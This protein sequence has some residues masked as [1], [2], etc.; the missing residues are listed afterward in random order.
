MQFTINTTIARNR[1]LGLD[2]FLGLLFL[3][4]CCNPTLLFDNLYAKGLAIP[5]SGISGVV[6]LTENGD[7]LLTDTLCSMSKDCPREDQ[8]EI[9]AQTLIN[10]FPTGTKRMEGHAR[11]VSWRG[12]KKDIAARLRKFFAKYG[13]Y[14]YED[15]INATKRY[16]DSFH[17]DYTYMRVLK[18]FIWKDEKQYDEFGVYS[19][20]PTSDLA[21]FL[22]NKDAG[23]EVE[24][25]IFG[26]LR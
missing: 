23:E 11:G 22:E 1:G 10:I 16:V 14:S 3:K 5:D 24:R 19:T 6:Y 20:N 13:K 18:Y 26:E 9:L 2:E 12:N 8:V 7:E 25:D 15:I 4:Y 17:E 21:D